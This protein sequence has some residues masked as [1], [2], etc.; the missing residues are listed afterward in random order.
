MSV[1]SR[2]KVSQVLI[3]IGLFVANIAYLTLSP[4][5]PA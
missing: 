2:K 3:I 1:E 4:L 5:F